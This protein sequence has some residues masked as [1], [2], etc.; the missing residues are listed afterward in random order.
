MDDFREDRPEET[1]S[2]RAIPWTNVILF[3]ALLALAVAG[4]LWA[5]GTTVRAE[6][7][8]SAS[9]KTV[10]SGGLSDEMKQRCLERKKAALDAAV[11]EGTITAEQRDK[12]LDIF[13]QYKDGEIT[14][15][16]K[17]QMLEDAGIDFGALGF[18]GHGK[19]KKVEPSGTSI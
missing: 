11:E 17:H 12:A 6:T 1:S 15:A 13:S 3:S 5:Y 2:V 18:G 7:T 19:H 16:E 8:G 10:H 14:H 4:A 9:G